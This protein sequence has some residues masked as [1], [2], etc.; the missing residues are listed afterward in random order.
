MT[1][2]NRAISRSSPHEKSKK[3]HKNKEVCRANVWGKLSR[4]Q[5]L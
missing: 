1:G 3:K 2:G 4:N 5:T